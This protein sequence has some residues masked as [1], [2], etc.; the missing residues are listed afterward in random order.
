M[1][2]RFK[3][4]AVCSFNL[5]TTPLLFSEPLALLHPG[6]RDVV[7]LQVPGPVDSIAAF[8]GGGAVQARPR[9]LKVPRFQNFNLMKYKFTFNL[10]PC[11]GLCKFDPGA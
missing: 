7:P 1:L 6:V 3:R 5:K 2:K 8:Q 10:E 4:I 11:F 9:G